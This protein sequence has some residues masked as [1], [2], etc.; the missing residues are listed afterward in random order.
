MIS[1]AQADTLLGIYGGIGRWQP[2]LEGDVGDQRSV[3]TSVDNLGFDR[4]SSNFVWVALEHFLPVIPNIR[5]EYASIDGRA[6][7]TN[8][9]VFRLGGREFI[10]NVPMRTELDLAYYDATLYYELLDNWVSLDVGLTARK[11]DGSVQVET[12]LGRAIGNLDDTIPMGYLYGGLQFPGTSAFVH[13]RLKAVSFDGDRMLDYSLSAG[14][15]FDLIPLLDLGVNIGYRSLSMD[16]KQFGNMY[17]DI[18]ADGVFA[19][20]YLHF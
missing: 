15:A 6:E 5:L 13:A 9:Q 19:E 16:S 2:S 12:D 18:D 7:S 14:Y 11:F 17:V 8:Q 20:V 4:E 1:T 10:A 3:I